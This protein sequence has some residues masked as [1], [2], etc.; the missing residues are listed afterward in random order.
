MPKKR[1]I[2]LRVSSIAKHQKI[3]ELT[4]NSFYLGLAGGVITL[5]VSLYLLLQLTGA[6]A[7]SGNWLTSIYG[8]GLFMNILIGVL[9]LLAV[10]LLRKEH[11]SFGGSVMLLC[12]GIVGLNFAAGL[13]IGPLLG[14]IAGILGLSEHEKMIR[15]HL[16]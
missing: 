15:K 1:V 8:L 10:L 5:I 4:R 13:L 14:I 6:G 2:S 7:L 12:A 9:M 3:L 11:H 16:E